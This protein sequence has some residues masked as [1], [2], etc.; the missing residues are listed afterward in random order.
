V[1]RESHGKVREKYVLG[2]VK[3]KVKGEYQIF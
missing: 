1:A 3:G 2:K